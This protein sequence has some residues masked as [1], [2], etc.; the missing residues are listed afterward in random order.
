MS[1]IEATKQTIL[2]VGAGI[3]GMTAALEAAEVGKQL[4]L[5]EK[6]PNNNC[7]N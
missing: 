2:D 6:I 7:P 5:I 3:S 1:D 4:I